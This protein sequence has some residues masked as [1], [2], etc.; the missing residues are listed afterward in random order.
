M[1]HVDET[2]RDTDVERYIEWREEDIAILTREEH[3]SIHHKGSK[4]TAETKQLIS[5]KNW[6]KGRHWSEED[7][8]IK[9]E[10]NKKPVVMMNDDFEVLMRF[11]SVEAA[12]SY[13]GVKSTSPNLFNVL[14]KRKTHYRGYRWC[15][16]DEL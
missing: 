3:T 5:D 10:A 6:M 15:Y 12:W 16:A 2:L 4:H 1:H 9:S 13:F 7:K 14:K 8:K 11:D